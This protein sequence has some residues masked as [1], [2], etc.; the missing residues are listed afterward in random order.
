MKRKFLPFITVRSDSM[1]I[2]FCLA[3]AIGCSEPD[4][5]TSDSSVS[6]AEVSA[7]SDRTFTAHLTSDQERPVPVD[8]HG[9]GQ[10]I[11]K[12]S[13]DG[14]TLHYKL[15]VNNV[16]NITQAHIHCG[17][18]EVAGPVIAFLFGF[19][20]EGVTQNGVLAEG[21]ITAAD[22]VVQAD[23]EACMGG[24]ANFEELIAKIKAGGTYVNVHTVAFP[25]GEIRGQIK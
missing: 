16:E 22:V 10:A 9:S 5:L 1:A 21:D 7:Y 3:L 2:L 13:K 15:I 17:G 12:L 11:F 4:G 14:T 19:N 18:T 8:T 20:E 25:G 6:D 24:V 23:S